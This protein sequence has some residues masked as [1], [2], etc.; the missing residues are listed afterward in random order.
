MRGFCKPENSGRYRD[1]APFFKILTIFMFTV[2]IK[3]NGSLIGHIYGKNL[4]EISNGLW[5][6]CYEY[7]EPELR[8]IIKG[9]VVYIRDKGVRELISLILDDINKQ[10]EQKRISGK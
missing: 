4:G 9:K 2:E 3:I 1:L 6:Y 10:E 7:Y 8:K 5:E